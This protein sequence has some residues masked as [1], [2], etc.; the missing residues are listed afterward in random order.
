MSA[1][2]SSIYSLHVVKK[3][4]VP[5]IV[6]NGKK[7]VLKCKRGIQPYRLLAVVGASKQASLELLVRGYCMVLGGGLDNSA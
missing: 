4:P 6:L 5:V 7:K 1:S 2:H 3:Q